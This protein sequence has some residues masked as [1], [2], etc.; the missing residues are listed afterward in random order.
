[1]ERRITNK[2]R[3][4]LLE[5]IQ[6][7]VRCFASFIQFI[8]GSCFLCYS[9]DIIRVAWGVLHN[10]HKCVPI[11]PRP[12]SDKHTM[13][14]C[15][16]CEESWERATPPAVG[17]CCLRNYPVGIPELCNLPLKPGLATEQRISLLFGVLLPCVFSSSSL[18][19]KCIW[20]F[21]CFVWEKYKDIAIKILLRAGCGT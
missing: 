20:L 17:P 2:G 1:M 15:L 18:I 8:Q 19:L 3:V 16:L 10:L 5:C 9:I 7:T 12:S 21:Y 11:S 4:R 6:R 14:V 13:P